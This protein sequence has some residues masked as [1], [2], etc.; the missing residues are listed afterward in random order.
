MKIKVL[1]DNLAEGNLKKEWGL[2]IYI[3]YNDKKI[4]LDTGS[5]SKFAKNAKK[6]NINLNQIDFGILS[7]AHYDHSNGLKKF[8]SVNKNAK[9]YMRKTVSEN[10]YHHFKYFNKY[11]GIHKGWLKKF[12]SRIEYVDKMFSIS[13]GITLL[14]HYDQNLNIIGER[15]HLYI[16]EKNKFIPDNFSHDQS[17][18]FDTQNGLVIFNSCSHAGADNI[19]KEVTDIFPSKK[20]HAIIGGF[21]LYPL[22]DEEIKDFAKR[23]KETGIKK[24]ITGHCTGERAFNILKE[25]LQ[26]SALQFYT[27]FE[28]D[29]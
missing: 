1:I 9:F 21:H 27:G 13:E 2:C 23:V 7:H 11:I 5:S 8:F 19:L 25:E 15:A 10:C 6:L 20:I 14:G 12:E 28:I 29:L 16:K 18:I 3:E 17:L 26:D 4:L 24:I 22:K